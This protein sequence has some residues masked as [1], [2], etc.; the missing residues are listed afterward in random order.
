MNP[1]DEPL[2][3][4]CPVCNQAMDISYDDYYNE[5]IFT[6]DDCHITFVI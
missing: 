1:Q 2:E 5:T 4:L 3:T 6:C